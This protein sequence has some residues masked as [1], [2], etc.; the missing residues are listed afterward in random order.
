MKKYMGMLMILGLG[1]GVAQAADYI[2]DDGAG[3]H[4]W[5]SAANWDPDGVPINPIGKVTL[6]SGTADLDSNV[7]MSSHLII[8]RAG[9]SSFSANAGTTLTSG[10]YCILGYGSSDTGT[11]TVTNGNSLSFTG[12]FGLGVGW[13]G[14]GIFTMDGGTFNATR[15]YMPYK[16]G[17][18]GGSSFTL[19][20]GDVTI[21]EFIAI[22]YDLD[23]ATSS[24]MAINGGSL[25]AD[26]FFLGH[27]GGGD[28]TMSGGTITL[29]NQMVVG[30]KSGTSSFTMSGGVVDMAGLFIGGTEVGSTGDGSLYLNG[31]TITSTND[32]TMQVGRSLLDIAGGALVLPNNI[33]D[34]TLYGN[35]TAYGGTGAFQY[36]Y[37]AGLN[38]TTITALAVATSEIISFSAFSPTVMKMVVSI[39][40]GFEN[41]LY[42]KSTSN[43]VSE[44][45]GGIPHSDD[46]VNPFETTNLTYSTEDA[47]SNRVIYI[48]IDNAAAFFGI[49]EAP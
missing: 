43:L 41:S 32:M 35:V 23:V 42:L 46:G 5:S 12:A 3:D 44:T 16:P 48:E 15:L 18:P 8:A 22:T 6:P 24:T 20:S 30:N 11:L 26:R 7:T 29:T 38:R 10:G 4:L 25:T 13:F 2:W 47:S 33:T 27:N 17:N 28:L 36:A 40:P 21:K 45:W 14:K 1:I 39:T 19:N 34:I 9:D 37:N 49:G 31:G